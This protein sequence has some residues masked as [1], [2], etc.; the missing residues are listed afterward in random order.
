MPHHIGHL[1]HAFPPLNRDEEA[2]DW[3]KELKMGNAFAKDMDLYRAITT[4]KR[5]EMLIPPDLIERRLEIEYN[6]VQC[7]YLGNKYEDTINA[8]ECSDL[9]YIP[10]SFPAFHDLLV[11]VYDCYLKIGEYEKADKIRKIMEQFEPDT[12]KK[13]ELTEAIASGNIRRIHSISGTEEFMHD[14]CR[15]YKSPQKAQLMN[16]I[17]PGTGYAY[18]GQKQSAWTSFAINT[19]FIAAAYH[20]FRER[21]YAAGIITS[22]LE[23]GW[24]VGGI[25]GAGIEA[26]AHNKAVYEALGK[27]YMCKEKL[28]PVMMF[29][30]TF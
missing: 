13:L 15:C 12:A 23:F 5:A 14:Y 8:F 17:I 25:N 1:P 29:Q 3:G 10:P 24:Y 30:T 18:L 22:S 28:F 19:L 20:F 4:Y 7:Y 27:K 16:A 2:T 21:N 6:I 9:K 26:Q 11:I